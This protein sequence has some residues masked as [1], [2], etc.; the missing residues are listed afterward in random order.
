[1]DKQLISNQYI[2]PAEWDKI[3]TKLQKRIRAKEHA[4]GGGNL[5]KGAVKEDKQL[6]K[7]YAQARRFADWSF[8][9]SN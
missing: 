2:P 5:K 4:L 7:M 3:P 6:T 1:M 9:N 8:M